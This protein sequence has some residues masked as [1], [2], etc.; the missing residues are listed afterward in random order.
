MI[1]RRDWTLICLK[2]QEHFKSPQFYFEGQT[3]KEEK[4]ISVQRQS[5]DPA[6]GCL[7]CGGLP[8]YRLS[9]LGLSDT[10]LSDIVL[11]KAFLL[12]CCF[13]ETVLSNAAL[14]DLQ[15][16]DASVVTLFLPV[17]WG[18]LLERMLPFW[19]ISAWACPKKPYI[20]SLR[21]FLLCVL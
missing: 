19:L 14:S 5:P 4:C 1:A 6:R 7:V 9:P 12:W 11:S 16:K 18:S 10:I 2:L 15:V 3:S 20:T 17:V 8:W 21:L 13:S